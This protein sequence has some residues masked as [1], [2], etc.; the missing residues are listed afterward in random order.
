MGSL[1]HLL[2]R[3]NLYW[4]DSRTGVW[5]EFDMPTDFSQFVD[6]AGCG[7]SDCVAEEYV[8]YKSF[9]HETTMTYTEFGTSW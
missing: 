5:K 3:N 2:R 1:V 8:V 6:V 7:M 4:I 9:Y